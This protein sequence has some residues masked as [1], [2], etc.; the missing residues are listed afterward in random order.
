MTVLKK[1]RKA[2]GYSIDDFGE[3]SKI[4]GTHKI[5][6]NPKTKPVVD[7]QRRVSHRYP[8]GIGDRS[9]LRG[10]CNPIY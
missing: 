10:K 6:V 5:L 1:H 9:S 7:K 4:L 2:F 8:T 3:I